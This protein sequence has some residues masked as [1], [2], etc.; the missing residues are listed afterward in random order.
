MTVH[1]LFVQGAGPNVHDGWDD[2][3]VVSLERELGDG[4]RVRYPQ[5]PQEDDPHYAA[6]KPALLNELATLE[7]GAI[8]VGH[9]IGGTMLI[10]ALAETSPSFRPGAVIL[11]AAPFIGD[12]GWPSGELPA[13]SDLGERLP[14]ASPVTLYHGTDDKTVPAAHVQL[15]AHAIPRATV[16]V[17]AG[18]DHQ[19]NNDLGEV[20]RDI[21]SLSARR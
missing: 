4:Y 19:L 8:L 14:D 18:R 15:Y 1:V 11:I 17:L 7:D 5:M 21:R 20:A 13:R 6:W 10:H 12:G 16:R 3:L 9:S 2:K